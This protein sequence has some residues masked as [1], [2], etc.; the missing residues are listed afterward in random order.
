MCK[1]VFVLGGNMVPA[2]KPEAGASPACAMALCLGFPVKSR[3][4]M[5]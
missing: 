1:C 5:G 4:L 2:I 3:F